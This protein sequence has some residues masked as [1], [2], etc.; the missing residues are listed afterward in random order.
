MSV[1]PK[2]DSSFALLSFVI[3]KNISN[4][5]IIFYTRPGFSLGSTF[6]FNLIQ[7]IE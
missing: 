5:I 1:L 4:K 7:G 2:M 3:Q 6:D